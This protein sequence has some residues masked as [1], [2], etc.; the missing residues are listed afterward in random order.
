LTYPDPPNIVPF[1]PILI[2]DLLENARV[3]DYTATCVASL[4]SHV[5]DPSPFRDQKRYG[6]YAE[7]WYL[8]SFPK[9][10]NTTGKYP[11]DFAAN[12]R[13]LHRDVANAASPFAEPQ[14]L[15]LDRPR[16]RYRVFHEKTKTALVDMLKGIAGEKSLGIQRYSGSESIVRTFSLFMNAAGMIGYHGAAFVN[17]IFTARPSC[18]MEITTYSD[19]HGLVEWRTNEYLANENTFL[20]WHKIHIKLQ[21]LLRVN[22][23]AKMPWIR[24]PPKGTH[25]SKWIKHLRFVELLDSDIVVLEESLKKC[26]NGK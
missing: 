23:M 15:L 10:K 21:T 9:L 6:P 4:T 17:A 7:K 13:A 1:L 18:V 26:L 22:G 14:L 19:L 2:P 16:S 3:V 24:G 12:L 11:I 20:S 25:R 5:V 8:D